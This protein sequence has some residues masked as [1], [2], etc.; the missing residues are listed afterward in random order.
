MFE[1]AL[2]TTIEISLGVS[3]VILLLLVTKPLLDKRYA[4]KW[5]YWVWLILALRLIFPFRLPLMQTPL[6]LPVPEQEIVYQVDENQ[7]PEIPMPTVPREN[8]GQTVSQ[9]ATA[10][11]IEN[12][13]I[14]TEKSQKA[15]VRTI[16]IAALAAAVW[17]GGVVLF[18]IWNI[19]VYLSFRG[20]IRRRG[21]MVTALPSLLILRKIRSELKIKRKIRLMIFSGL[22]SPVMTGMISPV[23][24]LPDMAFTE[25]ELSMILRHELVHWKRRD[26]WYKFVLLLAN[27]V[28]WFNPLVWVMARQADQD[29]EIS[30]DDAVLAG[31]NELFRQQYGQALLH[32]PNRCDPAKH[33]F[34]YP[35]FS[36]QK[37]VKTPFFQPVESKPKTLRQNRVVRGACRRNF[38]GK[39]GC[40]PANGLRIKA[41]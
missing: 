40:L 16:S 17:C 20:Q 39:S 10:P 38:C 33:N 35:V 1:E 32:V 12:D 31:K 6:S 3:A 11:Q 18:L 14:Q 2:R 5:R 26:I 21:K 25:E 41:T 30:C 34:L 22:D 29:I 13:E 37:N 23:I 24:L 28:H 9:S 36:K 19:A 27:A 8:D 7:I 15:G 4:A